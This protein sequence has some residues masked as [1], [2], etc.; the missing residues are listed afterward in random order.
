[1]QVTVL[2]VALLA[3]GQAAGRCSGQAVWGSARGTG[4]WLQGHWAVARAIVVVTSAR[5]GF[6]SAAVMWCL[7]A[8]QFCWRSL[9]R[10]AR[11]GITGR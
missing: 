11:P 2:G 3:S 4:G 5:A 6:G 8:A 10:S 9:G 7:V 1:V